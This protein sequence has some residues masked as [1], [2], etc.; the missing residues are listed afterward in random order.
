MKNTTSRATQPVSGRARKAIPTRGR[1]R[2]MRKVTSEENAATSAS[3][4]N[5]GRAVAA[6]AMGISELNG[7]GRTTLRFTGFGDAQKMRV[8]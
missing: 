3:I 1:H 8:A 5:E 4:S 7:I 6:V 2:V